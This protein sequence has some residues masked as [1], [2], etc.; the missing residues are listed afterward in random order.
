MI[1]Q[2]FLRSKRY[3]IEF[4]ITVLLLILIMILF[5]Q[6][7][8]F[9]EGREGVVLNDPIL[10]LF[11]PVDLTWLTFAVIYLSIILFLSTILMK[12][13]KL[14]LALQ[15]Y[16]LMVIFRAIAMYLTPLNPPNGIILLDDP[17]V[18]LFG[19]GEILTK[20]LFFSGHTAT[21]FLLFL[22]TENKKLRM[23]FLASTIVVGA[24]VLF[25]KVHYSIDVFA[26]FFFTF[27]VFRI[28]KYFHRTEMI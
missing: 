25:Q 7:L 4:I 28:I 19:Q 8:Q 18:Q 24:C 12:P 11:N 10:N 26:A 13:F 14:M 22:L 16:G 1:W 6:F 5:P 21:L 9:I 23:I 3:L 15:T 2:T 20:D 27:L 17:F